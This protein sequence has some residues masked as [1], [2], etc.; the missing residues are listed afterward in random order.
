MAIFREL[1]NNLSGTGNGSLQVTTVSK[2][3]YGREPKYGTLKVTADKGLR[4]STVSLK[5]NGAPQFITAETSSDASGNIVIKGTSNVKDLYYSSGTAQI[6]GAKVNGSSVQG[7]W[8]G[9]TLVAVPN[10]PGATDAFTFEITVSVPG[11]YAGAIHTVTLSNGAGVA[12]LVSFASSGGDITAEKII[13]GA[14]T[15]GNILRYTA[16]EDSISVESNVA[17]EVLSTPS[18]LTV[19]PASSANNGRLTIART[20]NTGRGS[21]TASVIVSKIGDT[22]GTVRDTCGPLSQNGKG[23]FVELLDRV[24]TK[25]VDALD[26]NNSIVLEIRGIT[27]ANTF[28]SNFLTFES[29]V[30]AT[31]VLEQLSVLG[32]TYTTL[33]V[34]LSE[35]AGYSEAYNFVARVRVTLAAGATEATGNM[36][37]RVSAE[38]RTVS[39]SGSFAI[40]PTGQEYLKIYDND[41]EVS[42]SVLGETKNVP[43]SS[44]VDWEIEW[45]N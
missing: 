45:L 33:P 41:T 3:Y 27:N 2:T 25:S 4:H 7:L 14:I 10:D 38:A 29:V 8:D 11:D 19:T 40:Q 13:L 18:W 22:T 1:N 44:N 35:D 15:G 6:V 43:V 37:V 28:P 16:G 34:A 36:Y 21:R 26:G 31:A 32:R 5:L 30:G 39:D 42:I 24:I 17:W 12:K 9:S 20:E 23:L